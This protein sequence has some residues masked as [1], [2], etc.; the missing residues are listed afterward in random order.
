MNRL[1]HFLLCLDRKEPMATM[2]GN[3]DIL[4]LS[5]DLTAVEIVDPTELRQKHAAVGFIQL[6]PLREG[7]T[8][9]FPALFEFREPRAFFEETVI[10]GAQ[11]LQ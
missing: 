2:L 1:G 9:V 11:T 3:G 6:E 5:D 10:G 7:K 8:I 4:W